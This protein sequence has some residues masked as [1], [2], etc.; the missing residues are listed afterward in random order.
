[1]MNKKEKYSYCPWEGYKALWLFCDLLKCSVE[2]FYKLIIILA[3]MKYP[4][5]FV[6]K[7]AMA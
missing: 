7:P 3:K 5:M 1:M 4:V 6:T 2:E